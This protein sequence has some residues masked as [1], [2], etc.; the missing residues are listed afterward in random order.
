MVR[1]QFIPQTDP[2][3]WVTPRPSTPPAEVTGD[4]P[5]VPM[6]GVATLDPHV[7]ECL[8]T[9]LSTLT[10]RLSIFSHNQWPIPFVAEYVLCVGHVDHSSLTC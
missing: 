2:H 6:G 7:L 8:A 3:A 9:H 1:V 10:L 4:L 5:S